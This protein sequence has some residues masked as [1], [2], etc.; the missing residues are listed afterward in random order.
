MAREHYSIELMREK[1]FRS[2]R[3]INENNWS[4]IGQ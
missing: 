3:V 2:W 1:E 4:V